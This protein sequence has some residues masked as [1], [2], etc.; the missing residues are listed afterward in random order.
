MC[1]ASEYFVKVLNGKFREASDKKLHFPDYKLEVV[2]LFLYWLCQKAL[3][4]FYDDCWDDEEAQ[5][6]RFENKTADRI[7]V[8]LMRVWMFGDAYFMP[9]LQDAAMKSM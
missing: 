2:K 6:E 7:R 3:P 9:A 4:D 1:D 5:D 8:T